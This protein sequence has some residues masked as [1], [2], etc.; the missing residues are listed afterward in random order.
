MGRAGEAGRSVPGGAGSLRPLPPPPQR[1]ALHLA[2]QA[3]WSWWV[4][5]VQISRILEEPHEALGPQARPGLPARASGP[6][7]LQPRRP[8]ARTRRSS[9]RSSFGDGPGLGA[10]ASPGRGAE[11]VR[12]L[13]IRPK[14]DPEPS[15]RASARPATLP[16][17]TRLI[18]GRPRRHP[19]LPRGGRARCSRP[20]PS[21]RREAGQ[22]LRQ[23]ALAPPPEEE[24]V[25][26]LQGGER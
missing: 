8:R 17:P 14:F 23:G 25:I 18:P 21:A 20:P 26:G 9:R 4:T 10:P 24:D 1:A 3:G 7:A 2:P 12:R 5:C 15:A 22:R 11:R 16:S 13:G 6:R 19:G